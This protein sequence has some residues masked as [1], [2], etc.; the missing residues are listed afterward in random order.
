MNALQLHAEN[1]YQQLLTQ[2]AEAISQSN[3]SWAIVGI[4]SGGAWIAE[5]LAT[6]LASRLKI[7][8][9]LP[10]GFVSTAMHRDD[11]A[12]RGM[13]SNSHSTQLSFDVN[14]HAILLVD[15]VLH[16]GRS[17]RAAVNEIF[18]FGRPA[19][20]DLAA[21]VDRGGRQ[22]PIAAR[23]CAHTLTLPDSQNLVLSR[24]T[25]GKFTLHLE[26]ADA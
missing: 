26:D 19:R 20:I 8:H 4:H 3:Q 15:D 7:E 9:A 21:L 11:F 23:F 10:L 2:I 5:R 18:D 14:D 12:Q 1:L 13:S 22:L 6:D 25:N 24:A 17:A 16:T